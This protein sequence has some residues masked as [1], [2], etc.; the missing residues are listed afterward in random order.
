LLKNPISPTAVSESRTL[1]HQKRSDLFKL[2]LQTTLL[3]S[4]LFGGV[5]L[6]LFPTSTNPLVVTLPVMIFSLGALLLLR[7][8]HFSLAAHLFLLGNWLVFTYTS[9]VYFGGIHKCGSYFR[10]V[11]KMRWNVPGEIT[12]HWEFCLWTWTALNK[13]TMPTVTK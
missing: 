6:V 4:V 13:S 7:R 3:V 11:Y 8:G 2:V 1:L 9:L 5:N 12:I 10:I